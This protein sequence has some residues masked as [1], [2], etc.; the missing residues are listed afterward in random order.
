MITR[1]SLMHIPLNSWRKAFGHEIP[2][3]F[4]QIAPHQQMLP[5]IR[6]AQLHVWRTV[7]KTAMPATHFQASIR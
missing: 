5:E 1:F 3:L 7:P 6:D 4:V 2:F